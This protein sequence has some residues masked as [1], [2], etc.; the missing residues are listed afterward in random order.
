MVHETVRA[1][2]DDLCRRRGA[3]GAVLEIGATPTPDSLLYLPA[4]G[5]AT[6][7]VGLDLRGPHRFRGVDIVRGDANAM[8]FPD[9]RF[10]TVLMNSVLEHDRRFWRTLAEVRRVARPGAL[11][12]LGVPGFVAAPRP[13]ALLILR[14]LRRLPILG[15]RLDAAL[16]SVPTLL[17]HNFPGDYYR[18]SEQ[19]MREVLLEGL[20]A[21][22]IAVVLTPPRLIGSGR[23]P[24]R[25]PAPRTPP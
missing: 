2:F 9:A 20:D 14:R 24:A 19:A 25:A 23:I 18:F 8:P 11:V 5:G 4:L 12:A 6:E 21:V 22:E 15:R 13:R 3:G 7:R 1:A 16:A 17:I 10:D